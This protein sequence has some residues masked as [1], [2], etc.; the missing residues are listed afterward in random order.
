LYVTPIYAL[1]AHI[2]RNMYTYFFLLIL[3]PLISILF[4][5]TTLFRSLVIKRIIYLNCI[6]NLL[7]LFYEDLR[8]KGRT[9]MKMKRMLFTGGGTA[10]HVTVN[11]ALIPVFQNEGYEIDYI[12]SHDGIERELIGQMKDV[13]YFPISTGKLR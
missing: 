4:P 3:L 9:K 1:Y 11:M 12:G 7:Y 5:Y 6:T 2:N 8:K 13:T 10:G